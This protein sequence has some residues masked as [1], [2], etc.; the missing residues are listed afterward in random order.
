MTEHR[1]TIKELTKLFFVSEKTIQRWVSQSLIPFS[2]LPSGRT[3]FLKAEIDNHLKNLDKI[4]NKVRKKPILG[5]N[6]EY[7]KTGNDCKKEIFS[8]E[9][10]NATINL[11][12]ISLNTKL[13]SEIFHHFKSLIGKAEIKNNFKKVNRSIISEGLGSNQKYESKS[14][15]M[16][17]ESSFNENFTKYI[18][19]FIDSFPIVGYEIDV[20]A[21]YFKIKVHKLINDHE[22]NEENKYI[23]INS[24]NLILTNHVKNILINEIKKCVN[25]ELGIDKK[26]YSYSDRLE[27]ISN[28]SGNPEK[29]ME[30]LMLP[31]SPGI[32]LTK[33]WTQVWHDRPDLQ[34]AF[35]EPHGKSQREFIFWINKYAKLENL[36]PNETFEIT[37]ENCNIHNF[38]DV[39]KYVYIGFLNTTNGLGEAARTNSQIIS[40]A[41]N[42]SIILSSGKGLSTFA[43]NR[44]DGY[45]ESSN[46]KCKV[47]INF[48]F[49]NKIVFIHINPDIYDIFWK[50]F[51]WLNKYNN[52]LIFIWAWEMALPSPNM[53]RYARTA[54][55][56]WGPSK[57]VTDSIRKIS[58]M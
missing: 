22:Q 55:E 1:Y 52:Y 13:V 3:I 47:P 32:A 29:F 44:I 2:K 17:F 27:A 9:N 21:E 45:K 41:I 39:N 19:L 16:Y 31:D 4:Q 40:A 28:I 46:C 35:P 12:E 38:D 58:D 33:Y 25:I 20:K 53:I 8:E 5:R 42:N 57:F 43:Y 50:D 56:I 37:F 36:Y 11:I 6:L 14:E 23:S 48:K 54:N 51:S 34:I 18:G 10:I 30:Y 7:K 26:D 49:K 24:S 15:K